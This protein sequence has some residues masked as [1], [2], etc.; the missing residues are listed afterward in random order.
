LP[1][2]PRRGPLARAGRGLRGAGVGAGGRVRAGRGGAARSLAAR[3]HAVPTARGRAAPRA[4]PRG[5]AARARLLRAAEPRARSTGRREPVRRA[6]LLALLA[7][8]VG[9]CAASA[10]GRSG[11][12]TGR[13]MR[14]A[15]ALEAN[16]DVAGAERV[17]REVVA[18][19]PAPPGA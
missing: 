4:Q 10:Q 17:L 9:A 12:R 6:A 11:D 18:R 3:P 13:L 5:P 8:L 1:P 7:M 2:A 19:Q 15:A 16:G 14:E